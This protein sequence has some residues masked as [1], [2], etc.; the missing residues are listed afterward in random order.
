MNVLPVDPFRL[1]MFSFFNGHG[2][3]TLILGIQLGPW[4]CRE[5]NCWETMKFSYN[6]EQHFLSFHA[7]SCHIGKLPS[8]RAL[9]FIHSIADH[10][11]LDDDLQ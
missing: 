9:F 8:Q 10:T 5:L 6:T 4:S 3:E 1:F 2:K 11:V 7:S